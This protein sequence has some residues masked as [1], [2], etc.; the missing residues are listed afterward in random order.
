MIKEYEVWFVNNESDNARN[1]IYKNKQ[2]EK[3]FLAY[4]EHEYITSRGK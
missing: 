1:F 4:C 3:K 2:L